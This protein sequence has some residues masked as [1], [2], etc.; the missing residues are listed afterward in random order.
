MTH[1]IHPSIAHLAVPLTD[2]QPAPKNARRGDVE[3]IGESLRENTQYKPIVVREDTGEILVGNHT[4][5]AAKELGWDEIAVLRVAVA[6]DAQAERIKL[7]DNRTADLAGYDTA[8]LVA[9]LES[10]EGLAGTGYSLDDLDDLITALGAHAVVELP[11]APTD[12]AYA[13]TPE[14]EAARAER[15]AGMT[16]THA[17]GGL[18][19]MIL[20]Y[21]EAD[22]AEVAAK[23]A[24]AREQVG[25]DARAAEIVLRALR[26]LD[27]VL[28]GRTDD[29]A[30]LVDLAYGRIPAG[31]GEPA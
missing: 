18:V 28:F 1:G 2:V 27:A 4:W 26:I 5:R 12:A 30:L 6:D 21:S 15:A 23:V 3:A 9:Q 8:E 22:R 16:N 7:A 20:V 19:D 29:F 17:A 13:E 10:L 14:E 31:L 11:D 24:R 25:E